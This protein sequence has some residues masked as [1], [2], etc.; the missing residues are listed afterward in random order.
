VSTY[1]AERAARRIAR[2]LQLGLRG[3]DEIAAIIREELAR[4]PTF[5][6][7]IDSGQGISYASYWCAHCKMQVHA[8][9]DCAEPKGEGK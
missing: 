7:E 5:V 1:S 8:Q 6:W 4:E 3:Q 2:L 9:H